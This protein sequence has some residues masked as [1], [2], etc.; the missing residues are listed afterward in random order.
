[1]TS[2]IVIYYKQFYGS[3]NPFYVS[4]T[5]TTTEKVLQG[6]ITSK[7]IIAVFKVSFILTPTPKKQMSGNLTFEN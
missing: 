6:A 1:M 7:I 5:P 4:S 3:L 2:K